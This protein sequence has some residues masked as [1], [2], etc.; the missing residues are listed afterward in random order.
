MSAY[1]VAIIHETRF[2]PAI[3]EYL[4]HIDET[5][6]PYAGKFRIHGGP[7]YSMEGEW[8][9][10]LVLIEF[11]SMVEAN[12]WYNSLA[13]EAIKPLRTN[14][15][16]GVVLLVPGVPDSHKAIDILTPAAVKNDGF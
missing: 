2:G 7:Y 12:G 5:L 13:Y 10:D 6:H 8:S 1:A 15:T 3:R 11:P 4:A 14:N 16:E 9:G